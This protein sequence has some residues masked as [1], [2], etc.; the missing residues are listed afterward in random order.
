[1]RPVIVLLAT[2]G[3][4]SLFGSALADNANATD[5]PSVRIGELQP[6]EGELMRRNCLDIQFQ[7]EHLLTTGTALGAQ[8][9]IMSQRLQETVRD[10]TSIIQG[11]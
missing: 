10:A 5:H 6:T 4:N 1:M 11:V 7:I 3:L 9:K 8:H 2:L